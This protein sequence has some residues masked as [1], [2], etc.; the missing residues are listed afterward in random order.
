MS[1]L[2]EQLNRIMLETIAYDFIPAGWRTVDE[3]A[4][5]CGS[6]VSHMRNQLK[7]LERLGKAKVKKFRSRRN[8][9]RYPILHYWI[10]SISGKEK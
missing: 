3:W 4:G 1:T 9:G 8:K 6:S 5:A 10:D 7:R 2:K